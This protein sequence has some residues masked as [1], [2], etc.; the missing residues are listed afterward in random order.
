MTTP[1]QPFPV[2]NQRTAIDLSLDPWLTP[3]DAYQEILD[4]FQYLGVVT[5]RNGSIWFDQFPAAF[6]GSAG[7]EYQNIAGVTLTINAQIT[8]HGNHGLSNGQLVRLTDIAGITQGSAGAPING[9]RWTVTVTG[10]TTF[11][12]NNTGAFAGAYTPNTGTLSTFPGNA[13]MAISVWVDS[14]NLPNLI[15]LDTKRAA[16]YDTVQGCLVPIGYNDQFT[17]SDSE[18]FWWENY[19]GKIFF[20]NNKDNIFYWSGTQKATGLT[21][22]TPNYSIDGTADA[23]AVVETCLMIKA[24]N[25]RLCLYNTVENSISQVRYPTRIRYSQALID[26]TLQSVGPPVIAPWDDVTPGRGGFDDLT[27]SLYLIS[28]GQIQTNNLLFSQNQLFSVLY[29]QRSTSDPKNPYVY[30]KIATSRNVNSTFG[31]VVLDRE[32]Q[33]VGNTG[34]ILTDGNSVGRYDDKIPQFAIDVMA[35][36]NFARAFGVRNDLLW[37]SWLLFTSEESTTSK[38]D[39]ILVFNYQDRS[40]Q[41]YRIPLSCAGIYPYPGIDPQWNTYGAK[42]PD[43]SWEDFGEDTW[44][45]LPQAQSPMLLGGSYDGNIWWMDQG[46]GD[47]ADN[48][49]YGGIVPTGYKANG[50]AIAAELLTRQWFPYAQSGEAAQFGYIDFLIDGDPTTVVEISFNVD[51]ETTN[52]LNTNFTCIPFEDL[53]FSTISNI[54]QSNPC[55]VESVDHGLETGN[56]I[57]IFAVQGMTELNNAFYTVTKINDDQISLNGVNSN[58]FNAYTGDGIIAEQAITQTTFWT[59]VWT[60]QT[61]VFHQMRIVASGVD[62]NFRLHASIPWFKATGR[63]YK[64]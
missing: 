6:K 58:G 19:F 11:T 17:G 40:W 13:I 60:G 24:V 3:Q 49:A 4:A 38:N 47:F 1:Y 9:T 54:T 59:R 5:K 45:S 37:Q 20:T 43:F 2:A 25:Q 15:V 30:V 50:N 57:Y 26:P 63:I 42:L 31:T 8:T 34:L 56:V 53:N 10:A 22:F 32:I 61:G 28:Q 51:N 64:G 14:S 55:I 27:D 18:C 33:S 46:G 48:I 44:G 12:I 23:T 29:E 36:D 52:Y 41:I 35:Q 7:N 39:Q 62:E 16:I 21:A